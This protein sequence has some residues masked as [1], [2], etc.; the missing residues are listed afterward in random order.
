[1]PARTPSQEKQRSRSYLGSGKN[2]DY[3]VSDYAVSYADQV[4]KDYEAFGVAV[5][6]GRFPAETSASEIETAI[7]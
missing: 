5:R 2:F 7:R 4:E 3:A 6:A 1:M